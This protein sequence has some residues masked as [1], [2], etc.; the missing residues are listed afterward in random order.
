MRRRDS[1]IEI[2]YFIITLVGWIDKWVSRVGERETGQ[3]T[4]QTDVHSSTKYVTERER[5]SS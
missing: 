5:T 2:A 1:R 4:R 3:S